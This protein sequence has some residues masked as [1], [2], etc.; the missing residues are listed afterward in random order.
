MTL[1][2]NNLDSSIAAG[3]TQLQ[4]I[5]DSLV[6]IRTDLLTLDPHFTTILGIL[7]LPDPT[8]QAALFASTMSTIL[9]ILND[10]NTEL[11]T[12]SL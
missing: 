1:A 11:Q 2:I 9:L 8:T 10:V 3:M 5:R 7:A 12:M 4:D 6:N